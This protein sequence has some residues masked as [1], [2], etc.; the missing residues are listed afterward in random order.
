MNRIF[1]NQKTLSNGIEYRIERW[2]NGS[3]T[4]VSWCFVHG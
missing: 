1:V 3:R 4:N 2:E